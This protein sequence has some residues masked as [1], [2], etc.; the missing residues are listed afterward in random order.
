MSD[1]IQE[2]LG[3]KKFI[4]LFILDYVLLDVVLCSLNYTSSRL[5]GP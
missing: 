5:S 2:H 3:I 1:C 4:Y